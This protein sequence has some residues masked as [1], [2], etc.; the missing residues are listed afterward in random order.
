M[1]ELTFAGVRCGGCRRPTVVCP[2]TVSIPTW[3][4][5]GGGGGPLSGQSGLR[6]VCT[7][8]AANVGNLPG[9]LVPGARRKR[10][11]GKRVLAAKGAYRAL[12][13][14]RAT[15]HQLSVATISN[16]A[17]QSHPT[18]SPIAA[19][20]ATTQGAVH[21]ASTATQH[22]CAGIVAHRL[23][24]PSANRPLKLRCPVTATPSADTTCYLCPERSACKVADKAMNQ[25]AEFLPL[26]KQPV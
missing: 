4:Q 5:Q 3:W 18:R 24:R 25:P 15:G 13:R 10:S 9:A 21:S 22:M 20:A 6:H 26:R 2:R 8:P 16:P 19:S 14:T 23:D 12:W 11:S 7:C 1:Y 17:F